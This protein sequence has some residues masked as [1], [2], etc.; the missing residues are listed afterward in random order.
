MEKKRVG[1]IIDSLNVS[2][3]IYDLIKLSET[4]DNYEICTLIIN[5]IDEKKKDLIIQ[6]YNYIKRRGLN[7]FLSNAIFRL[8][9]KIESL[10]VKRIGNFEKFYNR[11]N[12]NKKNFETI[13]VKPII[14]KNGLIY[15]Y[16][17][18]DNESIKKANLNLLIRA[19]GGILKGKIL[20]ICPNG[21]IS[22]HH[23][24]NSINRGGPPGFW[25]VYKRNART[26]FIIQRLKEK[27][28]DGDVLF[29]GFIVTKWFY[30]LNLAYLY[31][32]TVPFF[33]NVI[34]DITSNNLK[35]NVKEKLP[36]SH[37]LYTTPNITQIAKYLLKTFIILF[38][39]VFRKIQNKSIRFGVAYQFA[40]NWNDVSLRLSKK[41]P[42]PK[43]R[44]LADPFI[45]KKKQAH[46][47][48]VEDYNYDTK[49]GS[50][51]AYKI[52]TNGFENIGIVLQEDFHL[53][54]PFLFE[55]ENEIYMCPETCQKKEIRIYKCI[56]FPN[57]WVFHKT[58][59]NNI[60][61]VDTNIFELNGRWWLFTNIDLSTAGD[62]NSQLHI[63][64]SDNPLS[65]NW[66]AHNSNPVIFD[67]LVARNGGMI[68]NQ[69][70]IYR[71]FQQQGFDIY[72]TACGVAKIKKLSPSTY[73]EEI[74]T[75]IEPKF[76]KKI[77]GAHTLNF[78][79]GLIVLDYSE[80]S[81]IKS[82][83]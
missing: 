57:K 7:K 27:L 54:Y 24:D 13:N 75:K 15:S 48:F 70:E 73:E 78:N 22:T 66:I 41:I 17:H 12:L 39:K 1:I 9:C 53:S 71:V 59:I 19:G 47:C 31:E 37:Q 68:A 3:Q 18:K 58:L 61:A 42:N 83:V 69:K 14:S 29:K 38:E 6:I 33:H 40:E 65:Q 72:G 80:V 10:V 35:I 23:G 21:I 28:D 62:R 79:D 74:L 45:I 60:L 4:S 63:F 36:Y 55:Y 26:G 43:N 32:T 34:E 81:K 52:T 8:V 11:F 56:E 2:K 5:N 20:S 82:G 46:Y 16:D 30:N 25:E 51:S 76:F 67:P 44:F 50:I 77:L 64:Y 49:K